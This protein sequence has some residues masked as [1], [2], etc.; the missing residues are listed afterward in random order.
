MTKNS[1]TE[2]EKKRAK[3]QKHFWNIVGPYEHISLPMLENAVKKE[4]KI[5]EDRSVEK[6][7]RLMR[8]EGKIRIQTKVKVWIRK[9]H[10]PN[11]KD[12]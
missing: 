2:G 11:Q 7:I 3:L 8:T 5:K 6:Q 9:P 12:S 1:E 10:E 4:F